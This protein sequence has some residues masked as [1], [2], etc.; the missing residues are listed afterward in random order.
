MIS[1]NPRYQAG[2]TIAMI[3]MIIGLFSGWF[4]FLAN[5][6]I[7]PPDHQQ[8]QV[9]PAKTRMEVVSWSH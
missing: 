8:A 4:V 3:V 1:E 7:T 6:Q 9:E 5:Q 2:L